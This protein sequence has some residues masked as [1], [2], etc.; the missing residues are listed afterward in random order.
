VANI[1]KKIGFHFGLTMF[2][3]INR[4]E[5]FENPLLLKRVDTNDAPGGKLQS[6]EFCI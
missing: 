5:D 2:R 6:K 3:G 4:V 1:S